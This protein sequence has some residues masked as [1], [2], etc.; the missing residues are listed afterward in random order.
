MHN[1]RAISLVDSS[2]ERALRYQKRPG[3]AQAKD[4]ALTIGYAFRGFYTQG[5]H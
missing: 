1:S 3:S 4:L 5:K 2:R